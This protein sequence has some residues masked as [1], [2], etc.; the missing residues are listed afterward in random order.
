M[1]T[2]RSYQQKQAATI[3]QLKNPLARRRVPDDLLC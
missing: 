3:K 2:G 1:M